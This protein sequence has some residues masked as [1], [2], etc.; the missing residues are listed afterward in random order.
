MD[1]RSTFGHSGLETD[2]RSSLHKCKSQQVFVL[3]NHCWPHTNKDTVSCPHSEPT[4]ARLSCSSKWEV[5]R[6]CAW[7]LF[8]L[9]CSDDCQGPWLWGAGKYQRGAGTKRKT[10]SWLSPQWKYERTYHPQLIP[11]KQHLKP[12]KMPLFLRCGKQTNLVVVV[13]MWGFH[14]TRGNVSTVC[15]KHWFTFLQVSSWF[16]SQVKSIIILP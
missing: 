11:H 4:A 10:A 5:N 9:Y 12:C 7:T 2:F 3:I 8:F 13:K 16:F 6:L 1:Y 15:F 14:H